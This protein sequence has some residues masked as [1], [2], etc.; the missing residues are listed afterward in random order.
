MQEELAPACRLFPSCFGWTEC[1]FQ[2]NE[3]NEKCV[4]LQMIMCSRSVSVGVLQGHFFMKCW[5]CRHITTQV[6]KKTV[7]PLGQI[8]YEATMQASITTQYVII[9]FV[10]ERKKAFAHHTCLI[11]ETA[12]WSLYSKE[13]NS[14]L[15]LFVKVS[16]SPLWYEQC[17]K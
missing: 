3:P 1:C 5:G 6:Y 12:Q 11:K 17:F 15:F 8:V 2:L 7:V 10:Q 13:E 14:S 16:P 4:F 9:R